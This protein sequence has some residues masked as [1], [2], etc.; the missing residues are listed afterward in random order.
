MKTYNLALQPHVGCHPRQ[1]IFTDPFQVV[2]FT[3]KM[4]HGY[5]AR[6]D[7]WTLNKIA[8][9]ENPRNARGTT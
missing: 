2:N 8:P 6:T 3:T 9:V 7:G 4:L 5:L 1:N